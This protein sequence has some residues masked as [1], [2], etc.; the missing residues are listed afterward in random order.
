[1]SG[2]R[3]RKAFTLVE[4]MVV[5]LLLGIVMTTVC[6][7]FACGQGLFLDTSSKSEV[8]ASVMQALQRVSFELQDSGY[9]SSGNFK[10]S[11]LDNTGQNSTDILRF[12]IPL[13]ACGISPFDSTGNVSAWGAPLI[14]GQNGCDTTGYTVNSA[15]KVEICHL[16]PGNPTNTNTLSVSINAIPAH[17]AHGDYLGSCGLC[18][19]SGYTNRTI[20]YMVDGNGQL[21]RRVLNASNAVLKSAVIARQVTAFQVVADS[22]VA[23]AKHSMINV[24][25][26]AAKSGGRARV[27]S[28]TN[29]VDVLLRNR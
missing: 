27:F 21:L 25:V 28:V 13:C 23:P 24:T 16:P 26:A 22:V 9:D 4:L 7:L 11:I 6:T 2:Q 5:I 10:V 15:G 1:M 12:S 8:Q 29:N 19:P 3:L 20:E 14:W 18:S 17:L